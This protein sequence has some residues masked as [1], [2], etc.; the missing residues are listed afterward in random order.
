[1]AR[2]THRDNENARLF[3]GNVGAVLI[4]NQPSY[5]PYLPCVTLWII[6]VMKKYK[7]KT[8]LIFLIATLVTG[9]ALGI[10]V[11]PAENTCMHPSYC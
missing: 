2:K 5:R 11:A 10:E 6:Y 7:T 9:A 3:F 1:M 4:S 8:A